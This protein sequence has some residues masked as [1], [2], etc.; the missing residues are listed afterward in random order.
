VLSARHQGG[1]ICTDKVAELSN[2]EGFKCDLNN[3]VTSSSAHFPL[4]QVSVERIAR[5]DNAW[6]GDKVYQSAA[7]RRCSAI[8]GVRDAVGH[9][10]LAT[11]NQYAHTTEE[12][13]RRAVEAQERK[14][15]SFEHKIEKAGFIAYL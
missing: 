11:T 7:D 8:T 5:Q 13:E 9:K 1:R 6:R 15:V 12:G 2:D 3:Q 4:I 14:V 10:S